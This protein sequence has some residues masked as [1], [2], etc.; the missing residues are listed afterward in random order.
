MTRPT[1]GARRGITLTE[2]LISILIMAVGVISLATLFPLGMVRLREASRQNRS[3]LLGESATADL[4][5]LGLLFK[6]SFQPWYPAY[7][8][9]TQDTPLVG[10][11]SA[12][13]TSPG[14]PFCYDPLWWFVI[15]QTGT[16]ITPLTAQNTGEFRFGQGV[17]SVPGIV[18]FLRTDPDG[19]MASGYGL[20]RLTN[21]VPVGVNPGW[22][23][24]DPTTVFISP[25]DYVMQNSDAPP[26]VLTAPGQSGQNPLSGVVPQMTPTAIPAPL[27]DWRYTWL[28]TGQQVSATDGTAYVG[29][30]VVMDSRPL[31]IDSVVTPTGTSNT[32][33]PTASGEI[34][35]E[36][37][38]GYTSQVSI[39]L[40]ETY[41]YGVAADRTVL[42]RW[43]VNMP[44]PE[45]KV[46]SWIADVTYERNAVRSNLRVLN[47]N[48]SGNALQP[49]YPFQRCHWYQVSKK[50]D[51]QVD[52]DV[53]NYRRIIVTVNTPLKARTL[54]KSGTP[55]TPVNLNVALFMPSVVNV[56]QRSIFVR[57]G[58]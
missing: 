50:T 17:F 34:V 52:P 4:T 42:L 7:D 37:I 30:V 36:A 6:P 15:D 39:P 44:D 3:G 41:G 28:F 18:S 29:N 22:A 43:P 47:A 35:L 24:T 23:L 53:P 40:G 25:D 27:N 32:Q 38:F 46:G 8:P 56:F 13:T 57:T 20:P 11:V 14:L 10:G 49:I 16:K 33:V 1:A 55:V 12:T 58:N 19:N 48:L 21:F 31:A 45:I 26:Q 54:L 9:F 51:A 5:A 2:I